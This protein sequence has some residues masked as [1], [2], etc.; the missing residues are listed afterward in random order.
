MCAMDGACMNRRRLRAEPSPL[1]ELKTPVCT[2]GRSDRLAVNMSV[3][4]MQIR[5]STAS[6]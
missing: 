3:T 1:S 6:I 2:C 5:P 4:T